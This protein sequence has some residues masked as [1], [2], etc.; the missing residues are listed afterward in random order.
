MARTLIV[1]GRYDRLEQV[2][3][4]VAEAAAHAGLD[5]SESN[6]CQLAVDEACTNIIEHGYG[7]EGKG[8]IRLTCDAAPGELTITLQDTAQPFDP[9][10]VPEPDLSA[11]LDE[12]R[13]GGLGLYF[14]RQ[15]MDAVEF[16][17]ESGGN[18]LVL[19]K[20]KDSNL[21]EAS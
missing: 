10:H 9:S 7:G 3:Q 18:T 17:Y 15:V 14:M 4:F 19:I 13:I 16:S 12:L 5:E 6:H 11:P 20:R 8:E 1:P 21:N 2:C